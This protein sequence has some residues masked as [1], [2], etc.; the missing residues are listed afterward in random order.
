[1]PAGNPGAGMLVGAGSSAGGPS[2]GS[3]GGVAFALELW[4]KCLAAEGEL[5]GIAW[6]DEESAPGLDPVAS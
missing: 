6:L 5:A 3:A 4:C 1:M 2:D